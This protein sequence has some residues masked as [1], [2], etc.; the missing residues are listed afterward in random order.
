M[1]PDLDPALDR[2]EN[3]RIQIHWSEAWIRGSDPPQNVMDPQY[4]LRV[5]KSENYCLQLTLFFTG[6]PRPEEKTADGVRMLNKRA[7]TF[8]YANL[9]RRDYC[10]RMV[11]IQDT[12][13]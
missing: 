5:C 10:D 7:L 6:Q 2:N 12:R 4:W 13:F 1:D 11:R 3:G 8:D 9:A